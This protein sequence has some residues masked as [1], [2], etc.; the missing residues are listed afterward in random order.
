MPSRSLWRFDPN[1]YL[2]SSK[3]LLDQ[4]R[5]R[6]RRRFYFSIENVEPRPKNSMPETDKSEVRRQLIQK[7][8]EFRHTRFRKDIALRL[9]LNTTEK[10]P[11][12][13]Q[14]IAKNLLDLFSFNPD[15]RK[16][17]RRALYKDDNQISAL[18]VT[19]HHGGSKPRIWGYVYPMEC[20]FQDI[21]LLMTSTDQHDD[22]RQF[23][24][25]PDFSDHLEA[26]EDW[27]RDENNI[28]KLYGNQ[29]FES[30]LA[31]LH[32]R[33]Q[34]ALL[35][36]GNLS[37]RDLNA[38]YNVTGRSFGFDH[39]KLWEQVFH[40]SPLRILLD[41]FPQQ[42]GTSSIWKRHIDQKLKD[43][44]ASFGR[45]VNPL[46]VPVAL[47]VLI[48]PPPPSRMRGNP[49]L[50]NLLRKY[51]IPPVNEVLNPV[52]KNGITRFEAYR[53]PPSPEG[54]NGFVHIAIV[55]DTTGYDSVFKEIDEG[56]ERWEGSL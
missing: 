25:P 39:S 43:F 50:D 8:Q 2:S 31:H 6:K 10:N 1:H 34:E 21:H 44:Q 49:D 33:A 20:L 17:D 5:M 24:D 35:S 3:G 54:T 26:L 7:L 45:M 11:A 15:R 53:L 36:R 13:A 27:R 47:E 28:R 29:A 14:N 56:L 42:S 9:Y 51:I 32:C 4:Y 12:H 55:A 16:S 48:K 40:F 18:S 37:T 23:R 46:V 22:F 30:F 41:E 38:M 19:C 52:M